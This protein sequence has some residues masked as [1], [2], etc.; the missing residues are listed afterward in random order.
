[1]DAIPIVT[2]QTCYSKKQKNGYGWVPIKLYLKK[3]EVVGCLWTKGY[4]L[5]MPM[6]DYLTESQGQ[7]CFTLNV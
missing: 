3:K 7:C 1:M 5:Q 2:T 6:L 4:S